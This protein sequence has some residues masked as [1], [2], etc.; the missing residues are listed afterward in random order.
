MKKSVKCAAIAIIALAGTLFAANA[1]AETA[2]SE[3]ATG[4]GRTIATGAGFALD[5]GLT[6][7]AGDFGAKAGITTPWILGGHAAARISG[8]AFMRSTNWKPYFTVRAGLIGASFMANADIRLYGEGGALLLLP[9]EASDSSAFAFGG[10]GHFGFEF[11]MDRAHS[12]CAYFVELGSNGIGARAD[13]EAGSPI[14]LNGFST[15][16]GVRWYP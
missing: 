12:G 6:D 5:I 1:G 3:A 4:I 8:T 2:Q 16:V 7:G 13:R 14:Y 15:T 10:Y 9:P 11:F